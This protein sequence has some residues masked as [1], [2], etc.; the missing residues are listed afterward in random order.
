MRIARREPQILDQRVVRVCR[1]DLALHVADEVAIGARVAEAASAEGR[2][3][4]GDLKPE[5]ARARALGRHGG[6]GGKDQQRR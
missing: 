2:R 4:L 6:G 1:I 5:D 3:R